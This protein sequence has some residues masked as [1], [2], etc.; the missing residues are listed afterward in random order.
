MKKYY[1]IEESSMKL[2]SLK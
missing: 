2:K 1:N